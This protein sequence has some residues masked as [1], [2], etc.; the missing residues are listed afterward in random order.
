MIRDFTFYAYQ[1]Y[2]QAIKNS[3]TNI[4]RFDEFLSMAYPPDSFCLIRHDVDRRPKKA[5]QMALLENEQ[6]VCATYYFRS[7]PHTFKPEIINKIASLGHEIGYHYESLSDQK[8]NMG[9]AINDFE[10]NLKKLQAITPIKTLAMHGRPLSPFDNRDM[11]RSNENKF[12]L[13]EK[14]GVLGEVYLYIDYNDIAYMNDTGRNWTSARLNRRDIVKTG[15]KLTIENREELYAYLKTGRYSKIVFQVH[16]E[17]W[18]SSTIDY[19][20]ELSKDH[21]K[22]V[23]KTVLKRS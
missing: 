8:G 23:L 22:N 15:I 5:L 10:N 4:Y 14:Y 2:I 17:R 20:F 19:Y 9:L 3:Y 16:P 11:W 12:M 1:K 7:K 18:S 6:Q 21:L 13:R